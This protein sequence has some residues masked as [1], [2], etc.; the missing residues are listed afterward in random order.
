MKVNH[1]I[2]TAMAFVA[3][4]CAA[5]FGQTNTP[6]RY[7]KFSGLEDDQTATSKLF[8]VLKTNGEDIKSYG[9]EGKT[10]L[11]NAKSSGKVLLEA[12]MNWEQINRVTISETYTVKFK[13]K[14]SDVIKELVWNANRQF[15]V[16]SYSIDSDGNLLMKG[17]VCFLDVLDL[18]LLEKYCAWFASSDLFAL[19]L[20]DENLVEYLE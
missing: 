4:S 14:H 19:K 17:T 13:Y 12:K 16:G 2:V 15:N 1:I 9:S 6:T 18:T 11:W 10:L 3:I 8:N 5:V 7:I 20:L